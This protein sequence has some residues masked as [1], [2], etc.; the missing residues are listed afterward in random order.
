MQMNLT[1]IPENECYCSISQ[2]SAIFDSINWKK[3]FRIALENKVKNIATF[4][5]NRN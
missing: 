2:S 5:L 3:N 1:N 4:D